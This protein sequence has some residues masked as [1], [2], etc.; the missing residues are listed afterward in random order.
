MTLPK[1]IAVRRGRWRPHLETLQAGDTQ[2]F[3]AYLQLVHGRGWR[4]RFS[5]L[6]RLLGTLLQRAARGREQLHPL[7]PSLSDRLLHDSSSSGLSCSCSCS[8]SCSKPPFIS[9]RA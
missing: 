5:A 9:P 6:R 3:E 1:V 7:T 2:L 8:C 4:Q